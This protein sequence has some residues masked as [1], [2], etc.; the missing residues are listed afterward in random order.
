[1]SE[2]EALLKAREAAQEAVRAL[3]AALAALPPEAASLGLP[4]TPELIADLKR[5]EGCRLTAYLDTVGVWTIGYGHTGPEVRKGLKWTQAQAEDALL[6]D[7]AEHNAELL[8]ALP[9]AAKLDPVRKRAL[10]NM[11]FN[12]G[13][14]KLLDFKNT[15]G[16]LKAGEWDRC[17]DG[18]LNSLWATQVGDRAKRIAHMFRTGKAP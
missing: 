16:A 13:I 3:D 5:D 1:M 8:K 12:L 2:R 14:R 7:A 6:T 17:A 18:A 9:W 15:L 11:A 4:V 10:C